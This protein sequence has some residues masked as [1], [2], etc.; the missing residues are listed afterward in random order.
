MDF[1]VFMKKYFKM[2]LFLKDTQIY[3]KIEMSSK[4]KII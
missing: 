4:R 1:K 3:D 2:M